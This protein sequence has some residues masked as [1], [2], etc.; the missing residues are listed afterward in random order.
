MFD[1]SRILFLPIK[2]EYFKI[3]IQAGYK[4]KMYNDTSFSTKKTVPVFCHCRK[5]NKI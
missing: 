3:S 2:K 1:S 4:F 5:R